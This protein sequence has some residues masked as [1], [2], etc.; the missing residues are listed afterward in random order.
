MMLMMVAMLI[1]MISTMLMLTIITML[2]L[3]EANTHSSCWYGRSS[4][5]WCWWSLLCWC[6]WCYP[7]DKV[8]FGVKPFLS[9]QSIMFLKGL[10][11]FSCLQN[12]VTNYSEALLGSVSLL[13]VHCPASSIA[14]HVGFPSCHTSDDMI[15]SP[16]ISFRQETF[17]LFINN[18]NIVQTYHKSASLPL[19]R[20][21]PHM[22][23]SE[24]DYL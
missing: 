4:P 18:H 23:Q 14:S 20:H 24:T 17:P 21:H 5:C 13:K 11:L 3:T 19:F 2:M 15:I 22:N 16:R 6:W 10:C 12:C 8:K 1:L 7:A 9:P